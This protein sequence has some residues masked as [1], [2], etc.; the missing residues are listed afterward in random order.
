MVIYHITAREAWE[1]AKT[2]GHYSAPSLQ[3]EGFIHAS[4]LEQ[5][6]GTAN[7]LF[8]GQPGLVLLVIDGEKLHPMLRFDPV[9]THGGVTEFPHIY[10]P[11]NLSAVIEIIDFDPEPDGSFSLP[12]QLTRRY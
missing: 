8:R 5:V 12:Q 7:L 3:T 1:Q 4:T 11:I 9:T 2:I 10:G 6:E